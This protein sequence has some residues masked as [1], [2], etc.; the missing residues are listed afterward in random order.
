MSGP[1]GREENDMT[2]IGSIKTEDTE[3]N[4]RT[5][6][7][8]MGWPTNR[9]RIMALFAALL[10]ARFS[11]TRRRQL[12]AVADLEATVTRLAS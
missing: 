10:G 11:H 3:R 2:G 12:A 6:M 4:R 9:R 8:R 7:R 1:S 5:T